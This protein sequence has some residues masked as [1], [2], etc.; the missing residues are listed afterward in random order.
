MPSTISRDP[1]APSTGRLGPGNGQRPLARTVD[2]ASPSSLPSTPAHTQGPL[3]SPGMRPPGALASAPTSLPPRAPQCPLP[4][5]PTCTPV[6]AVG[7][8][9]GA[10]APQQRGFAGTAAARCVPGRQGQRAPGEGRQQRGEGLR[11]YGDGAMGWRG[12][13]P[14]PPPPTHH[15]APAA[16]LMCSPPCAPP[17]LSLCSVGGTPPGAGRRGCLPGPHLVAA[18]RPPAVGLCQRPGLF[19]GIQGRGPRRSA[20]WGE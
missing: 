8:A 9:D 16:T 6:P 1:A 15:G 13:S 10:E 12:L 17:S 4:P 20:S 14:L 18:R 7:A 2:L 3:Q 5:S 11:W 19:R